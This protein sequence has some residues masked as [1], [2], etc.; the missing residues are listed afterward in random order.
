VRIVTNPGT[1]LDAAE[2]ARYRPLLTPQTIVVDGV[3]HDTRDTTSHVDIDAWVK[4]AKEHP[5]VLGTSAARFV[6]AFRTLA[7]D[8][9]EILVVQG[10]RHVIGS[11]A[12]AVSG[13]RA[14]FMK[15]MVANLGS[16][17]PRRLRPAHRPHRLATARP[18]LGAMTR[19]RPGC[20]WRRPTSSDPDAVP[21]AGAAAAWEG[22][23]A[24]RPRRFP[25]RRVNSPRRCR[26]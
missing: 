3:E 11:S 8:H 10:S 13:G 25:W 17:Q 14:S 21:A 4:Q 23:A 26:R 9:E 18:A 2:I 15:A 19:L 7:Q 20:A 5:C 22:S 6:D 24:S 16:R 12:S 1:N